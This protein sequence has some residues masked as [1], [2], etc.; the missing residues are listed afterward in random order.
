MVNLISSGGIGAPLKIGCARSNTK[1]Q[2]FDLQVD[3]Q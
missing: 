3:A 1:K 2:I